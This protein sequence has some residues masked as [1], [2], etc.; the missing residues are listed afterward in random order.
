[1]Q[2]SGVDIFEEEEEKQQ[3]VRLDEEGPDAWKPLLV[4]ERYSGLGVSGSV[5]TFD[6]HCAGASRRG[7]ST[8]RIA[9]KKALGAGELFDLEYEYEVWK[10]LN[11]TAAWK[12]PRVVKV[13]DFRVVDEIGWVFMENADYNLQEWLE[14]LEESSLFF[15][16]SRMRVLKLRVFRDVLEGL[17]AMKRKGFLHGDLKPENVLVLCR[18]ARLDQCR[19]VLADFGLSCRVGGSLVKDRFACN[20]EK[21]TCPYRAPEL[22]EM[23]LGLRRRSGADV[24]QAYNR[25]L[26][27]PADMWAAGVV[28]YKLFFF[29]LPIELDRSDCPHTGVFDY[30]VCWDEELDVLDDGLPV[31]SMVQ[32]LLMGLLIAKPEKRWTVEDALGC[33]LH[34]ESGCARGALLDVVLSMSE[35]GS[36]P[37]LSQCK[38]FVAT[39]VARLSDL[40]PLFRA[41]SI[42]QLKDGRKLSCC[43]PRG[44]LGFCAIHPTTV[45]ISAYGTMDA[46]AEKRADFECGIR[47]MVWWWRSRRRRC[48]VEPSGASR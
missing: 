42:L 23:E 14:K 43:C 20:Y 6:A 19:G 8:G 18:G 37:A 47:G 12:V 15:S 2:V 35:E 27:F 29:D 44:R 41:G 9:V 39:D 7:K 36:P 34:G 38:P 32:K 5:S 24:T 48:V 4:N 31:S 1:M 30:S 21:Y 11:R 28:L 10:V 17:L 3:S 33:M 40:T 46:Q 45:R 26:D 25:A 13:Y 22:H 16:A